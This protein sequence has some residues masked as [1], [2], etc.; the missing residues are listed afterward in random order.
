MDTAQFLGQ[1]ASVRFHQEM[2]YSEILDLVEGAI[3]REDI[4]RFIQ[5]LDISAEDLEVTRDTIELLLKSMEVEF[6]KESKERLDD[7]KIHSAVLLKII[8][9]IGE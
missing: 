3:K 7:F 4:P 2:T 6:P 5:H 9:D 8:D 1:K